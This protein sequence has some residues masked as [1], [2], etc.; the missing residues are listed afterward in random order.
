MAGLP[1]IDARGRRPALSPP[2]L[3]SKLGALYGLLPPVDQRQTLL[4]SVSIPT[5]F[6]CGQFNIANI[7]FLLVFFWL[8]GGRANFEFYQKCIHWLQIYFISEYLGPNVIKSLCFVP[9]L[10]CV[11]ERTT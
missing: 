2:Q 5:G 8:N 11:F 10:H 9:L 6:V 7:Q 4:F 3:K 1:A